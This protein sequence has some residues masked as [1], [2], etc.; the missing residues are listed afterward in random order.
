MKRASTCRRRRHLSLSNRLPSSWFTGLSLS[1][2]RQSPNIRSIQ[3]LL[4]MR[5]LVLGM[6]DGGATDAT[7]EAVGR[8][9][10]LGQ[11]AERVGYRSL[12]ALCSMFVPECGSGAQSFTATS[13]I[14][15]VCRGF[16]SPA[17]CGLASSLRPKLSVILSASEGR[18]VEPRA[19]IPLLFGR[20]SAQ[21][22]FTA[23]HSVSEI[24]RAILTN[25]ALRPILDQRMG[26]RN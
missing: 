21:I 18:G 6:A 1:G 25:H 10:G 13:L 15:D 23:S 22:P 4:C 26:L 16:L 17:P 12:S 2:H 7:S 9:S 3:D 24:W 11:S 19:T 5:T 8:V 14:N 20:P